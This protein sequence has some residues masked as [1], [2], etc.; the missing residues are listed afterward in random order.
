MNRLA[1]H[2]T[3]HTVRVA[4]FRAGGG[5]G[6]GYTAA[7]DVDSFVTD[8]TQ[9][10]VGIDGKDTVSSANVATNFDELAPL[11]SRVTLWPGTDIE[12]TSTVVKITR[13]QHPTLPWSQTLWLK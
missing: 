7:R 12:R 5:L 11:G 1:P 8:E 10:I 6:G 3:P 4:A 13:F 9:T 2:F